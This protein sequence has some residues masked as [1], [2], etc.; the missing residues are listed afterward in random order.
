MALVTALMA[1]LMMLA[2][3][4][5]VAMTTLTEST[6]AANHRDG[7]Q[8]LYAAEAGIDLAVS[9]LR[10]IADWQTVVKGAPVTLL[11]GRLADLMQGGT[12]DSRVVVTVT[13]SPDPN[14]H[15]DILA[16]QSSAIVSGGIRR[17]VQVSVRSRP[18]TGEI[19]ILSWR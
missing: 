19:E 8:A 10:S 9:R 1:M 15:E 16:L 7:L 18:A 2:L 4:A 5:G 12:A 17:T 3:G 14:G 6:I 13:V 11:D